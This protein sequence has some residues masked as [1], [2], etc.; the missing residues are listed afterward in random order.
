MRSIVRSG[1]TVL[2]VSHDLDAVQEIC[3]R[4]ILIRDGG[5]ALDGP[6]DRVVAAH[7]GGGP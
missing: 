2:F 3:D 6:P 1:R 7:L 4:A 5:I